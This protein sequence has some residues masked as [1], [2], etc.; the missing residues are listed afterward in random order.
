MGAVSI[1]LLAT[2]M[3]DSAQP[4]ASVLLH[5]DPEHDDPAAPADRLV[6]QL[7]TVT[8]IGDY[9]WLASDQTNALERLSPL[10]AG[11]FGRHRSTRIVEL[12]DLPADPDDAIDVKGLDHDDGYLWLV[13]SHALQRVDDTERLAGVRSD[14]NRF[15]LARVPVGEGE[16]GIGVC[17]EHEGRTAARLMGGRDGNVLTDALRTDAHLA[18]FLSIPGSDNGFDVEG[19]AVRGDRVFVGL[20]GPVLR[21]HAIVL[22]LRVG[23]AGSGLLTLQPLEG[24]ALY[25][26]HFLDLQGLGVRDLH[27][28]GDD[29]LL[30]AGPSMEL[31]GPTGIFRWR[32]ALGAAGGSIVGRDE[33]RQVAA[34]PYGTGSHGECDHPAGMVSWDADAGRA[35]TMLV[36]YDAPHRRR[37]EGEEAVRADVFGISG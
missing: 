6:G 12:L 2:D 35:R 28:E 23:D 32:G 16:Y 26:K 8:R 29:L 7:S 22:E 9:L 15:L 20:R 31:D 34:L 17:R 24:R 33:L 3:T 18:P 11:T 37:I 1:S 21:G 25:R 13:G 36:V 27:A 4:V 10:T 19:I 30:L 14:G 5:F